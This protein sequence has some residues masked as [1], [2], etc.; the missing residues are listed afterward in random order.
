MPDILK[1]A[2]TVVASVASFLTHHV[3]DLSAVHA[4]L[5]ELVSV[6]P[7]D[8]QDKA[9]IAS[10]LDTV[11]NSITNITDFLDRATVVPDGTSGNEVVVKESDIRA[12]VEGFLKSADGEAF[13]KSVLSGV[14]IPPAST[15]GNANG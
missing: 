9:R 8:A 12:A 4:G 10:G 3:N 13:V 5:S 1:S 2:E 15:E 7:I 14:A 11:Q 6:A